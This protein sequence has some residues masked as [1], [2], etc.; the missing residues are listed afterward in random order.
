MEHNTIIEFLA[1]ESFSSF[2][3]QLVA[4][5]FGALFGF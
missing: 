5:F 2:P 1:S 3:L 4:T